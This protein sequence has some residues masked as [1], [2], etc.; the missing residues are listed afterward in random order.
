MTV[1]ELIKELNK[2]PKKLRDK[3]VIMSIDSEGNCYSPVQDVCSN[4]YCENSENY[5]ID[6]VYDG[7]FTYQDNGFETQQ[8]WDDFKANS[9]EVVILYP[10]N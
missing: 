5:R 6:E 2:L 10:M 4:I 8:E 1:N 7:D 9:D 3:Q